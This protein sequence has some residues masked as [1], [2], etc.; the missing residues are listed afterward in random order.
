MPV[1]SWIHFKIGANAIHPTYN[2]IT[3]EIIESCRKRNVLV[4]V[5][6]VNHK[7]DIERIAAARVDGI[8]TDVPDVA[9]EVLKQ[10]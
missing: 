10:Y 5:W 4:N 6:T 1:S 9:F 7:K 8:I 2:D 3:S